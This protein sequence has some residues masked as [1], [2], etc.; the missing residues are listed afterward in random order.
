MMHLGR[1]HT[2]PEDTIHQRHLKPQFSTQLAEKNDSFV[3]TNTRFA[4]DI[5]CPLIKK[6]RTVLFMYL[7]R[8]PEPAHSRNLATHYERRPKTWRRPG[9]LD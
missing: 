9:R 2:I 7:P 6:I 4:G 5:I 1:Y 3:Q 8:R